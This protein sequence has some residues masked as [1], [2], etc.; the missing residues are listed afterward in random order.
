MFLFSGCRSGSYLGRTPS[1]RDPITYSFEAYTPYPEE[2]GPL[3]QVLTNLKKSTRQ[4]REWEKK[5]LW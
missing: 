1:Y 3:N 5:H 2:E 4:I